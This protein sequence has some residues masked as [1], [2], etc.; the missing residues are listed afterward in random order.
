MFI[1]AVL[2]AF[3]AGMAVGHRLGAW[4]TA[5]RI[6]EVLSPNDRRVLNSRI[7]ARFG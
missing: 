2:F 5:S 3:V 7:K 1:A 6:E 4:S